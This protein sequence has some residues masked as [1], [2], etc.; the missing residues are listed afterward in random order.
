MRNFSLQIAYQL[1]MPNFLRFKALATLGL[2]L[3]IL[4]FSVKAQNASFHT[5]DEIRNTAKIFLE[6]M[7]SAADNP[8]IEVKVN[9]LDPRLKLRK[10]SD[11]LLTELS[12]G[13]KVQGKVTVAVSCGQPVAWKIYISADIAEYSQVIVA[14]RSLP[15][16]TT[17][18]E[19]DIERKSVNIAALRKPPM[20]TD[21]L[22]V[23]S[24]T[25]RNINK[26]R[27]I[28]EDS[29]CMVCRGDKVHITAK[30]EFFSI[31]MEA[32]ALADAGIG[33]TTL[34]RNKQSKRSFTAKVV[35]RDRLEVTL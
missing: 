3:G 22:V 27:L 15:R 17:I 31:N 28:F 19:S 10:C 1:R 8:N 21:S 25:K 30:S 12:R 11:T 32:V 26:G 9:Q 5:S 13:S 35:S 20:L 18:T 16:K 14:A 2:T 7:T 23:G 4:A 6:E 34:V 29:V 33:E 24:T